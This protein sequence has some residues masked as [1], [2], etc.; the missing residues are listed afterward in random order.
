MKR[1]EIDWLGRMLTGGVKTI[2]FKEK[3]VHRWS[4]NY[5]SYA[6]AI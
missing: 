1:S 2:A 3:A 5:R 6:C 4:T